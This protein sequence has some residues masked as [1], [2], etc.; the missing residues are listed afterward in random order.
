MLT[1]KTNFRKISNKTEGYKVKF[2]EFP[3]ILSDSY[4]LL[5]YNQSSRFFLTFYTFSM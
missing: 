3:P 4:S 1:I 2:I 5:R